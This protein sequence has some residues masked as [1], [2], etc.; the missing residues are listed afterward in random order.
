MPRRCRQLRLIFL[1]TLA[2]ARA[3]SNEP[4][5]AIGR[6]ERIT[7]YLFGLLTDAI[8]TTG[9]LNEADDGPWQIVV[10]DD[11]TILEILTFAENVGR[12]KNAEFFIGLDGLLVVA[13]RAETPCKGCRIIRVSRYSSGISDVVAL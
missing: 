4:F 2:D 13:G 12:D 9:A 3:E 11:C 6:Q 8:Y 7:K 5:H 10:H 1:Q